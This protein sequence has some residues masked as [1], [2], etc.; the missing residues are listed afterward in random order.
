MTEE[1]GSSWAVVE[2][3]GGVSKEGVVCECEQEQSKKE[4]HMSYT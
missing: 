4:G 1:V 3:R 2:R